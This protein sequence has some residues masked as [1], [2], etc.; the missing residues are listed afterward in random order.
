METDAKFL[1]VDAQYQ[2]VRH[3]CRVKSMSKTITPVLYS[4]G[5]P[6]L[7]EN[8]N[9][10]MVDDYN[11]DWQSIVKLFFWSIGKFTREICSVEKVILLWDKGPYYKS[12]ICKNFKANRD[13]YT[14]EDLDDIDKDKDPIDYKNMEIYLKCEEAKLTAKQF[15]IKEFS[16]LGMVSVIHE[17]YEADDLCYIAGQLIKNS[18]ERSVALS[19]D[20][21]W[22]YWISSNMDLFIRER[23]YTYNEIFEETKLISGRTD[24]DNFSYKMYYDSIFGSHNNL[25]DSIIKSGYS[26]PEYIN[27]AVNKTYSLLDRENCEM[28]IKT[29]DILNYPNI[30]IVKLDLINK[31]NTYGSICDVSTKRTILNKNG[32]NVSDSYYNEFT[33]PLNRLLYNGTNNN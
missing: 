4:N 2:L 27:D 23:C 9:C 12:E 33:E 1:F 5:S 32:I 18:N 16:K 25:D 20:S 6:V 13:Y 22:K 30:D 31:M 7:D 28:N 14:Q 19:V 21:D 24:L 29:F 8:N 3:W 15:I 26:T 11:I 10:V 17:G